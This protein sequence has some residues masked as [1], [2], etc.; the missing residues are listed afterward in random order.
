VDGK[1]LSPGPQEG[2]RYSCI[3]GGE[4]NTMVQQ[5]PQW[6][7]DLGCLSLPC[8]VTRSPDY[9]DDIKEA[10]GAGATEPRR[11]S[12]LIYAAILI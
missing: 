9:I 7:G 5:L 12:M 4:K 6:F 10:H 1:H 2:Q 3:I 11:P 8:G